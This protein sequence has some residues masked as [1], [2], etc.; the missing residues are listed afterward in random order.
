MYSMMTFFV[1]ISL[2]GNAQSLSKKIVWDKKENGIFAHFVYG[3]TVTSKGT[4]LAMAEARITDGKDDGAHHLVLKRSIDKGKSFSASQTVVESNQGESWTNPTL[5]QDGKT[6]EIFLFYALN[7]QNNRTQVFYKTSMD[8]G[9]TWSAAT[10]LTSLFADNEHDWTFHLPGPGHGIQLKGGRLI[11]QVWHRKAISN[12]APDR[13]YGVNCLYSDDH[14][15][16]WQVGG[17]SPI[18]EMNE[19]Q[20]VERENGDVLLIGRMLTQNSG[21]F[22][23]KILSADNGENWTQQVAHDTALR[24][25]VCDVG[26]VSFG[27]KSGIMI[28]SQPADL[29]KRK[30]LT[31]R[32][33]SDE[34][35]TWQHARLLQEGGATYSDLSV[36]PDKTIICLYG[37]GGTQHMPEQVSFARFDLKWI[38]QK[39][40]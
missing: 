4:I 39:A 32:M 7:H 16:T 13:R 18:G 34:G 12:A 22:Q 33:S 23:A 11:V 25:A 28:V 6:K 36:L 15:K 5:L 40:E 27:L 17:D 29:K 30:A 3:L 14:G 21:S 26:L 9:L 20:L 31:I 19:S 10:E 35:K 2:S 1:F 38:Q 8:D 24:G 37:H